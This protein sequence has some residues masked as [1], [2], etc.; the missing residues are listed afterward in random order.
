MK[1]IKY[2][3]WFFCIL[4]TGCDPAITA[5]NIEPGYGKKIDSLSII[6]FGNKFGRYEYN[7]K[8]NEFAQLKKPFIA[9]GIKTDLFYYSELDLNAKEH[10]QY[11]MKNNNFTLI[12]D[13]VKISTGDGSS[14]SYNLSLYDVAQD[15]KVWAANLL[16]PVGFTK[17]IF[18]RHYEMGNSMVNKL[19]N[20]GLISQRHHQ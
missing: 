18:E 8:Q 10:L 15:K 12:V 7:I 3:V 6:Y 17:G 16:V 11:Y 20:S 4:L 5:S 13:P 2:F 9:A 1:K 14:V 19:I